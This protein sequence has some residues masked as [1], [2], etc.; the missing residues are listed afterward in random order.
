MLDHDPMPMGKHKGED[1]GNV[2]DGYLIWLYEQKWLK[3]E[4]PEIHA[5]IVINAPGIKDLILN[6]EDR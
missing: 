6:K 5:Y 2:P 4:R 3:A 1:I